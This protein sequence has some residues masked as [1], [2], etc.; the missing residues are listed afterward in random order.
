M[1]AT[2]I[3][4]RIDDLGRVVIPKEIRKTLRIRDGDPL[5]I[6]TEKDGQVIFKKYSPVE[7]IG[8]FAAN[9]CEAVNKTLGVSAAICDRDTVIAVSGVPKRELLGKQVSLELEGVMASKSIYSYPGEGKCPSLTSDSDR[10]KILCA[11][12]VVSQGDILGA[13]ILF[14]SEAKR[15]SDSAV[16]LASALAAFLSRELE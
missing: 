8:D 15:P 3:V 10:H 1:K 11:V 9:L 5:E 12:S 2:G 6:F 16:D 13:V 7:G 4:R 14:D